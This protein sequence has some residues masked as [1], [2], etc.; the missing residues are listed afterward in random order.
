M[1]SYSNRNYTSILYSFRV[2]TSYLSKVFDLN[3]PSYIWRPRWV[4]QFEFRQDF[5]RQKTK[6]PWDIVRRCL[7]DRKFSHFDTIP[8]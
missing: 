5:W 2:V 8:A 7:R 3:L 1:I 6:N 4:T